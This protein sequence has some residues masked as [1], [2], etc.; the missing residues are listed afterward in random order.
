M[1][2]A[3]VADQA[4]IA[5][6]GAKV[7]ARL[8]GDPSV[9]KLPVERAEL[10]SVAGFVSPAECAHIIAT[11]DRVARP[12][13]VFAGEGY[14]DQR[15]SY[16]GDVERSDSF[17]RMIER[18]ICDLMGIDEAW[19]ET[20]QGQRYE[21]GQEFQGHYD[22]FN[23]LAPY[24]PNESRRGGQRCWTAMVYLNAIAAGG[25]T[26]FPTLG[27]SI[28]PQQGLLLMWNNG[29]ADGA[30]NPDCLHAATP[31]VSGVKYVITKWFRTR[32]WR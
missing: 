11:I 25:E 27:I 19:G 16:S 26:E 17:V 18:R 5:R 1:T 12:S 2:E 7:R 21:P 20:F 24:W 30:P 32:R 8:A 29:L 4:A 23:T 6:I 22:Y 28:P 14:A 10:F 3:P 13:T 9:Y 31:V 15:T